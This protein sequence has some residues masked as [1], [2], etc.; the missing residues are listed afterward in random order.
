MDFRW[1]VPTIIEAVGALM[2]LG[3]GFGFFGTIP[4]MSLLEFGVIASA[5]VALGIGLGAAILGG[6]SHPVIPVALFAIVFF[7]A[8][9]FEVFHWVV[10]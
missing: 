8:V 10:V 1:L 7:L 4:Q 9:I 6:I 5:L 3:L 2:L